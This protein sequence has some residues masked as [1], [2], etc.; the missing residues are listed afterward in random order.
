VRSLPLSAIPLWL[1]YHARRNRGA[2]QF[3]D[4]QYF[5]GLYEQSQT[6][7]GKAL[8]YSRVQNLNAAM[9]NDVSRWCYFEV[10]LFGDPTI[11]QPIPGSGFAD[12]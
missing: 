10:I 7:L 8:T 6:Q 9:S 11:S 4:R 5:I 1:V 12:V 2:S 3:Y